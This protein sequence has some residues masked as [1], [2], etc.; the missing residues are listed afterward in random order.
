MATPLYNNKGQQV[1]WLDNNNQF[2]PIQKDGNN[3]RVYPSQGGTYYNKDGSINVI[4]SEMNKPKSSVGM[5][6]S[7][8][9]AKQ[10]QEATDKVKAT[11]KNN[12]KGATGDSHYNEAI[13]TK[14]NAGNDEPWVGYEYK[15]GKRIINTKK[16]GAIKG[17][18]IEFKNQAEAVA[19]R[20][21]SNAPAATKPVMQP[22]A[23]TTTQPTQTGASPAPTS[24]PTASPSEGTRNFNLASYDKW[25]DASLRKK[26]KRAGK[27]DIYQNFVNEMYTGGKKTAQ[28]VNAIKQKYG[29][30]KLLMNDPY[31]NTNDFLA[32]SSNDFALGSGVAEQGKLQQSDTN[33]EGLLRNASQEDLM[34]FMIGQGPIYEALKQN[35]R[36][37]G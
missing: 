23:Q 22:V 26:L 25:A 1:G 2:H 35:S 20:N 19:W 13:N 17:P 12:D 24:A 27:E 10:A 7:A 21:K 5:S 14:L 30:D 31:F 34:K 8:V 33:V 15:N 4:A 32:H 9:D 28:Q 36:F 11:L 6:Q 18:T 16:S 29:V 37:Y 3:N